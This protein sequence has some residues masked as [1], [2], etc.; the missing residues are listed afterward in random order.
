MTNLDIIPT[1]DAGFV[2]GS[3][4]V[5]R[6]EGQLDILPTLSHDQPVTVEGGFIEAVVVSVESSD[7]LGGPV[8]EVE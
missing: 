3:L 8:A 2:H 5:E 6:R 1:G 4:H 7:L